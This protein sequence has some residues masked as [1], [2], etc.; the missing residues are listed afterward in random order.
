MSSADYD[1]SKTYGIAGEIADTYYRTVSHEWQKLEGTAA[2]QWRSQSEGQSGRLL[3]A[4]MAIKEREHEIGEII[5]NK[6]TLPGL[7]G[8]IPALEDLLA[9]GNNK[10]SIWNDH[11]KILFN[12]G[13]G[14]VLRHPHLNNDPAIEDLY[15][16]GTF[17]LSME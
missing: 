15:H 16:P 3:A 13:S 17:S 4:W 2:E 5:D 9:H 14:F 1:Y 11:L 6:V 12:D 10:N 7:K 8:R